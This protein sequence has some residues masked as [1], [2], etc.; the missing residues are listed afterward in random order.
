MKATIIQK[1]ILI[2]IFLI[3]AICG[4]QKYL[5][6]ENPSQVTTDFLYSTS[7]GL[8]A[9]VTG[10]YT[11]ERGEVSTNQSNDFSF[12]MGDAG[13]DLDFNRAAVPNFAWYRSDINLANEAEVK[14]WWNMWYKIIER[15]NEIITF[16]RNAQITDNDK[17]TILRDAYLYRAYAYFWLVRKYDNIWL[18]T[19]PTTSQN[20]DGRSFSVAKQSDV[21]SLIVSDLNTSIQYFGNDWTVVPGK[22]N[23]G[24]ARLLLADVALWQK[25]YQTAA[26][27][28]TTIINNG[29]FSLVDPTTIFTQ[30]G[31]D[32]TKES[33][34][35]M[36]FD[37]FASG[38]GSS[39]SLPLVFSAITG[40]MPG[41][42]FTSDLGGYGWARMHPNPYLMSLYDQKYDKRY[43]AYWKNFYTYN[44]AA[45]DF[46]KLT[47]HFGDTLKPNQNSLLVGLNFYEYAMPGCKKYWDWVKVPSATASYNNVYIFRYPQV[48]LIAAEA[49]MNL[50]DN[51]KALSYINMIR[52]SRIL[53]NP[54][55]VLT[56]INQNVLI[57]EYARE[58]GFEGQRWF[59]LKRLGILIDRI[60]TY[61]GVTTFQGVPS[62]STNFYL[63]RTNVQPFHIRWPIPQTAIDAMGGF[64]QNQGY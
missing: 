42:S 54:N 6:E 9:A 33:M 14:S 25:D 30:D 40:R 18:D 49:Y 22:F 53:S 32:N 12:S 56:S 37:Q 10:L 26:T 3:L 5:K 63:C 51:V 28:S 24:V 21:Y 23:Q 16:G 31:R 27:Q 43:N 62:P 50:G 39:H 64:P 52:Q 46:S 48:L 45:F 8:K 58:L 20:V 55:Q 44:N 7:N 57:D 38:G 34:Y 13:T 19:I 1:N 59:L 60:K 47:Y 4:C 61:G 36:Q 29:P 17:K 15:T 35:V 2:F 11:I 41:C